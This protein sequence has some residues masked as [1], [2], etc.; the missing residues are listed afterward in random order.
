MSK[1]NAWKTY[2]YITSRML[3]QC[4]LFHLISPDFDKITT[5]L[6]F[7]SE[8]VIINIWM[9]WMQWCVF[10]YL[11]YSLAHNDLAFPIFTNDV[12]ALCIVLGKLLVRRSFLW[13]QNHIWGACQPVIWIELR[14]PGLKIQRDAFWEQ[15]K[16]HQI[17][18]LK[19]IRS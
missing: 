16:T 10:L 12:I 19:V 18:E 15:G 8:C 13:Y 6:G 9:Y 7:Y 3:L 17:V 4:P 5:I 14:R 2:K 1:R 11:F